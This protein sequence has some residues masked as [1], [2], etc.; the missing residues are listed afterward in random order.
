[1]P[2]TI[3]QVRRLLDG[4]ESSCEELTR[5]YLDTIDRENPRLN[6]LVRVTPETALA[7][8]READK[9]LASG[10]I[11]GPLD[12]VP[13]V[14]KDNLLTAGIPTTCCSR[15]LADY[16]PPYDAAVWERLRAAG[17]VLLGKANMD[18]FGMGSSGE[19]SC[20]GPACHPV[21]PMRTAGGSSGGVAA[22]VAGGL[23]V[24]G[25][26]SD[27][28]GSV[29]QPAA[30]CGLVGLKPTYG[31]LSRFGL[32]AYAS[33]LDQVGLLAHSAVDAAAIYDVL[34]V[35]DDR[36]ETSRGGE[37]VGQS[38]AAPLRGRRMALPVLYREQVDAAVWEALE[39]TADRFRSLG[40][41]VRE[42]VLPA[43]EQALPAYY[44][45]ASAEASS[46]LARYDG[47]R[48]GRRASGSGEEAVRRCRSEGFGEEVRRRILLGTFVL[49]EGYY[50]AYYQQAQRV[51]AA[52]QTAMQE[53][54]READ[55]LL[56]PTAPTAAFPLG[57]TAPASERWR[58]DLCT[59][60]ASL[61][62]L[63]AVSVPCGT[64]RQGLP[65]GVQLVGA[66]FQEKLLLNAAYWLEQ[67]G[68]G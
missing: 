7:A 33:S 32:V 30:F 28:G 49:S 51:R 4:R 56:M 47:L 20:F 5:R 43:L 3:G 13:M 24:Y 16:V 26:G 37:P 8:A 25:L 42:I 6:A 44:I 64:D 9:R 60:P 54:L 35:R 57:R 63:P 31:A 40:A 18:E 68:E 65:L 10:E 17:A 2:M 62:G 11:R 39:E 48:Y 45:L 1:M 67:E 36:D 59:V 53:A 19:T 21:D 14:L 41:E 46:N 55:C 29:R 61:A 66:A 50:A 52:V 27:T 34:A 12:G 38:L 15:M 58:A 22:A 23:A